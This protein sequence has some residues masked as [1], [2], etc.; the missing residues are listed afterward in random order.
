MEKEKGKRGRRRGK[1]RGKDDGDKPSS[2][3][4][5]GLHIGEPIQ[6][7]RAGLLVIPRWL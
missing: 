7:I 4:F 3:A 2:F 1:C 5:A 6:N